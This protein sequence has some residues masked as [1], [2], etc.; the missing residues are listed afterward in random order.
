MH[1][2]QLLPVC[3][4]LENWLSP[5]MAAPTLYCGYCL[6]SRVT[7]WLPMKPAPPVTCSSTQLKR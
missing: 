7:T 6:H 5:R 2:C 1:P 3:W 4:R